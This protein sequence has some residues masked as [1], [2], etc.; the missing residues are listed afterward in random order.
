MYREVE[1]VESGGRY[2][3]AGE[4]LEIMGSHSG[5]CAC[6]SRGGGRNGV[7]SRSWRR[8]ASTFGRGILMMGVLKVEIKREGHKEYIITLWG[9]TQS[10]QVM[11]PEWLH[12]T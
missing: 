10:I 4:V 7:P 6:A 5:L 3:K 8:R 2:W 9:F 12:E 1:E 11:S